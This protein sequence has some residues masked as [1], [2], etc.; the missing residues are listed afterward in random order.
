MTKV[1]YLAEAEL[2]PSRRRSARGGLGYRR[3]DTVAMA[4]KFA[5]EELP[6][7]FLLGAIL[8]VGEERFGGGDIRQL[9]DSNDYPLIREKQRTSMAM[10]TPQKS[11]ARRNA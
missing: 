2:F 1:N 5:I 6:S 7:E 11:S 3:F 8:E 9:Y 4:I 10:K